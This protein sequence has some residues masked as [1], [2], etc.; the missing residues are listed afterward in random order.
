MGKNFTPQNFQRF[1]IGFG[2]GDRDLFTVV[3]IAHFVE[4]EEVSLKPNCY[5]GLIR[6]LH[7]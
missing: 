2:V 3:T 6:P 7:S 5:D 4:G 1:R